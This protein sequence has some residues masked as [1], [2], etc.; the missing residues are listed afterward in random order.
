VNRVAAEIAEEIGVF[1]EHNDIHAR[2][3]QQKTGDHPG[4]ASARDAATRLYRF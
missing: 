2:A 4:R 1:F 3:S